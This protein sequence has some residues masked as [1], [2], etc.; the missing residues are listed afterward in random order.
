M[1][2]PVAGDLHC[3]P[4]N[5]EHTEVIGNSVI[6]AAVDID[7]RVIIAPQGV[8][9]RISRGK[10]S[11]AAGVSCHVNTYKIVIVK[12]VIP[13]LR[14]CS[15]SEGPDIHSGVA[16]V[17]AIAADFAQGCKIK[18][19]Q[20]PGITETP[21]FHFITCDVIQVIAFAAEVYPSNITVDNLI[22]A[23]LEILTGAYINPVLE[24][25]DPVADNAHLR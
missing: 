19:V 25:V 12:E 2:W 17:K 8:Q 20:A 4:G 18:G 5:V 7:S 15:C 11:D 13:D 23:D 9:T 22:P 3:R 16:V 1:E 6:G 10:R 21:H 14:K 24:P